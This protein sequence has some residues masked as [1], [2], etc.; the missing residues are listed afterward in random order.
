MIKRE[1]AS[2]GKKVKLTFVQPFQA[3]DSPIS[4]VGDFNGWDPT[5]NKL[6]KQKDG[7]ASTS[8]TVDPGQKLRFRYRRADG[9][10]FNDEAADAYEMGEAGA[11][12]CVVMS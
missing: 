4:V 6:A 5:K 11:E 7:T 1:S 8:V 3:S 12:N 9:T 2:R 10:W